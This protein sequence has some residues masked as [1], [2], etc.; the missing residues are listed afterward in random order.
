METRRRN[1]TTHPRS[2]PKRQRRVQRKKQVLPEINNTTE[3]SQTLS[4][5]ISLLPPLPVSPV[6]PILNDL[7]PLPLSPLNLTPSP[8]NLI[9]N[10]LI[11]SPEL[12][13]D[14]CTPST[15][16]PRVSVS[17]I[18]IFPELSTLP[19]L[20]E[21]PTSDS[22]LNSAL[23]RLNLHTTDLTYA[24]QRPT[25][26]YP[27]LIAESFTSKPT[28]FNPSP[29]TFPARYFYPLP[30]MS[31]EKNSAESKQ[32]ASTNTKYVFSEDDV[33]T[34]RNETEMI[35]HMSKVD[36]LVYE[37][38]S[39]GFVWNADSIRGL[40]YQIA[41]PPEMTKEINK[42]LD[43]KY[44][45][46][47]PNYK[48][49]DIKSA[50]QIYLTREKTASETIVIS[51]LSTQVDAMSVGTR[52]RQSTPLRT[53]TPRH[54]PSQ[55]RFNQSY[56]SQQR[57]SQPFTPR[58]KVSKIDPMRW[59]QGPVNWMNSNEPRNQS[60]SAPVQIPESAVKGVKEGALQCF[61]CGKFGHL[62]IE[63]NC[64][65][66]NGNGDRTGAHYRDWRR[67]SNGKHYILTPW[68][69]SSFITSKSKLG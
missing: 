42:D 18:S 23:S 20:P 51:N 62:Y 19:P 60:E 27:T 5:N 24:I 21:S 59:T 14:F 45:S 43:S 29:I 1:Y 35:A 33:N 54:Q 26:K 28:T 50:I 58:Q 6:F 32:D 67:T 9:P 11:Q 39:T 10:P 55:Q 30:T 36:S 12:K 13:P 34:A 44:D 16:E 57:F 68:S 66:Y 65:L 17:P 4:Y 22:E 49:D 52:P 69:E 37:I 46:K 64:P 8:P 40:F 7:P 15:E 53:P 25:S 2:P 61:F 63:G 56:A 31:T 38:Q 47:N 41:M 3:N 48:L